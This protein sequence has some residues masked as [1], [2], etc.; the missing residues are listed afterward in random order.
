MP[1]TR[2]GRVCV[3]R[4]PSGASPGA[5]GPARLTFTNGSPSRLT[6]RRECRPSGVG[7]R[8]G[9]HTESS[10]WDGTRRERAVWPATIGRGMLASRLG[11]GRSCCRSERAAADLMCGTGC[12]WCGVSR[13]CWGPSQKGTRETSPTPS[14]SRLSQP[15]SQPSPH[16]SHRVRSGPPCSG[17]PHVLLSGAH[18]QR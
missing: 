6:C 2:Q 15:S 4:R 11:Q 5:P 17:W 16:H 12:L 18:N 13:L 3:P 8:R 1:R 14:T 9:G 7:V 10:L